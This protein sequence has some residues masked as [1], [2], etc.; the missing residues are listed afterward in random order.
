MRSEN[1]LL[2]TQ[3]EFIILALLVNGRPVH[4]L[5]GYTAV[6][7][8]NELDFAKK[9]LEVKCKL[10]DKSYINQEYGGDI[11]VNETLFNIL[12]TYMKSEKLYSLQIICKDKAQFM[13]HY[14][15][16][17]EGISNIQIS[18]ENDI[19]IM[20]NYL[21]DEKELIGHVK[22]VLEPYINKENKSKETVVLSKRNYYSFMAAM[23]TRKVDEAVEILESLGFR[24]ELAL[25]AAQGFFEKNLLIYLSYQDY[26]I[27]DTPADMLIFYSGK[28]SLWYINISEDEKFPLKLSSIGTREC[29]E[30]IEQ[31][32]KLD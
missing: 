25:D 31:F 15:I 19:E 30:S 22:K 8:M 1:S 23:N 24:Y 4:G 29:L 7:D 32:M 9:W 14:Y 16:S 3:E 27:E 6:E 5:Q 20:L 18:R 21:K 13:Y 17:P 12:K 10:I 2:L 28:I 26:N 11:E